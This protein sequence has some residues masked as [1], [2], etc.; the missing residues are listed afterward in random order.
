MVDT[1]CGEP[2]NKGNPGVG[3][4]PVRIT[5][6]LWTWTD[7]ERTGSAARDA[8]GRK[9]GSREGHGQHDGTYNWREHDG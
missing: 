4:K 8:H 6:V 1:A 9:D 5:A 7:F 2:G 3:I